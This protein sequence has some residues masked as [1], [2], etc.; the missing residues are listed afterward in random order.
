MLFC[1]T[2]FPPNIGAGYIFPSLLVQVF[3]LF[4]IALQETLFQNQTQKLTGRP[5]KMFLLNP[6]DLLIAR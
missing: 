4:R 3:F 6:P 1:N 5:L 2:F